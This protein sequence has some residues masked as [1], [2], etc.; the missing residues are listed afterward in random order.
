MGVGA[1]CGVLHH[2][3]SEHQLAQ[4][5]LSFT[6]HVQLMRRS[7]PRSAA[8]FRRAPPEAPSC[9][10]AG[11]RI[12]CRGPLRCAPPAAQAAATQEWSSGNTRPMPTM[13]LQNCQA[14]TST[15]HPHFLG[16]TLVAHGK[17]RDN[18]VKGTVF[19]EVMQ[20]N[21]CII[22][23]LDPI[24]SSRYAETHPLKFAT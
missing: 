5:R 4:R 23:R 9:A 6:G 8:L 7:Q 15:I 13:T 14:S 1:L 17:V 22:E 10:D 2:T 24:D 11:S 3:A 21:K 16:R 12:C 19:G 18:F 20:L